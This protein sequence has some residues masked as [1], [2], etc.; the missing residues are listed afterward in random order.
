MNAQL[1]ITDPE[2]VAAVESWEDGKSYTFTVTQDAPGKFTA[3]A[4]EEAPVEEEAAPTEEAEVPAAT[5]SKAPG[6]AVIMA[7]PAK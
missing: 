4:A 3:T 7:K 5:A 1:T 6:I 2:L